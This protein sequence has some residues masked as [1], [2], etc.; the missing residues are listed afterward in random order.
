MA[1]P[2][3]IVYFSYVLDID[4][5]TVWNDISSYVKS[6]SI[7]RGKSNEL[8]SYS[9]GTASVTL[10]NR[11]RAFEPE[12]SGSPYY[13]QIE[14]YGKLK[15]VTAGYTEF[16]GVIDNW[17]FA[18]D[19]KG[20][21]ATAQIQANDNLASLARNALPA[22]TFSVELS[23][24]RIKNIMYGSGVYYNEPTCIDAGTRNITDDT[25]TEGTNL[26]DYVQKVAANDGG[27]FFARRDGIISFQD[28]TLSNLAGLATARKNYVCNSNLAIVPAGFWTGGG[29]STS[30]K[31]Q[32][33]H[34]YTNSASYALDYSELNAGKYLTDTPY[35]ISFYLRSSVAQS[36]L[37]YGGV[38]KTGVPN[39][40]SVLYQSISMTAGEVRRI[41]LGI[42][43]SG[44]PVDGITFGVTLDSKTPATGTIFIDCAMVEVGVQLRTY[45]DGGS[46]ITPP[47]GQTYAFS[48]EGTTDNSTS[49][50]QTTVNQIVDFTSTILISDDNYAGINFSDLS[51]IYASEKLYNQITV[52][53]INQSTFGDSE[54]QSKYGL[55]ELAI[56][57][58]IID[59]QEDNDSLTKLLLALYKN[60]NYRA[61][62]IVINVHGLSASEQNTMLNMDLLTS[63]EL[64]FIPVR[65]GSALSRKYQ[66]IGISHEV[67]Q[68]EHV[69]ELRLTSLDNFGFILDIP[70]LGVLDTNRMV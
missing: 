64:K 11:T 60:P 55:K 50:W 20:F 56:T 9:T 5:N 3:S 57:D 62:S 36:M 35:Y 66:V 26:L 48:F 18:Y 43:N 4:G 69:M 14:P 33:T 44:S 21:N 41:D 8:D 19:S 54:S 25:I 67:S 38:T 12:Y 37:I 17:S 40:D 68:T 49:V 15:I 58:S 47:S 52:N 61:E 65:S 32:G 23:G 39:P 59:T 10:D 13:G 70:N 46:S 27:L 31:Y 22:Q 1:K 30:W 51:M 24:T 6:F 16:V 53:G 28:T 2:T 63:I 45:F 7:E 29:R 34:S 42:S